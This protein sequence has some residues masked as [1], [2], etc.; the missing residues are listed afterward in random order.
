[1]AS[2]KI[3]FDEMI[4]FRPIGKGYGVSN[5]LLGATTVHG[6]PH[7]QNIR[8]N[9]SMKVFW[10]FIFYAAVAGCAYIGYCTVQDYMEYNV[11]TTLQ[12]SDV[13][14]QIEKAIEFPAI[15]LCNNAQLQ[16]CG[17]DLLDSYSYNKLV[18]LLS[19]NPK[20]IVNNCPIVPK[21]PAIQNLS[22]A[23]LNRL[24]NFDSFKS[25][26]HC[27]WQQS[28]MDCNQ[29]FLNHMTSNG[30]CFTFNMDKKL[31]KTIQIE[32]P[33]SKSILDSAYGATPNETEFLVMSPGN[34]MGFKMVLTVPQDQ[35]C[36]SNYH[37]SAGYHALVHDK[38]T[39]PL[40]FIN[41]PIFIQP[42]FS[43]NVAME[44][45]RKIKQ[46]VDR[47]TCVKNFFYTN[48][49]S[50]FPYKQDLCF[51]EC[52]G[53]YVEIA[54]NCTPLFAPKPYESTRI[55]ANAAEISNEISKFLDTGA[56]V[57]C[58]QC[59][60]ACDQ[61]SYD[62]TVSKST[63]PSDCSKV[64]WK[65]KYERFNKANITNDISNYILQI[66]FYFSDVSNLEIIEDW[67]MTFNGLLN[68]LGGGLSLFIGASLISIFEILFWLVSLFFPKIMEP[69]RNILPLDTK[70]K[71]TVDDGLFH[72]DNYNYFSENELYTRSNLTDLQ[73][74]NIYSIL[75]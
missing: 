61:I 17:L 62:T 36:S 33:V 38:M 23:E 44:R 41:N 29:L 66:N 67:H 19:E 53:K 18:T 15:T 45:T 72:G 60:P 34:Q 8:N 54:L 70:D 10:C 74:P 21:T 48:Y 1:M 63:F 12:F 51:V 65:E 64:F 6:I 49:P 31:L 39:T 11:K 5:S 73:Q 37:L 9:K 50:Y 24:G 75:A 71:A 27:E 46:T 20:E 59:K 47:G 43:L 16:R 68:G 3:A 42:G 28:P 13:P 7:T 57:V 26:L 22:I 14:N 30:L 32:N 40:F 52:F 55:C 35:F 2:I 25:A 4:K 69:A 56:L 58:P